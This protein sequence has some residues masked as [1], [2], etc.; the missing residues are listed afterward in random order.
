[1][2]RLVSPLWS[3]FHTLHSTSEGD[4]GSYINFFKR[5]TVL[6]AMGRLKQAS[7]DLDDVLALKPDFDNVSD[8]RAAGSLGQART[9]AID[10]DSCADAP[11]YQ[12]AGPC[13]PRRSSHEIG[14]S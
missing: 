14:P 5:A 9:D 12:L 2:G 1:M 6:L 7:R 3:R 4:A 8:S 13:P 10:T 11:M